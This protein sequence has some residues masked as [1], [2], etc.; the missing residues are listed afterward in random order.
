MTDSNFTGSRLRDDLRIILG[1]QLGIYL[2]SN[3]VSSQAI[4]ILPDQI[5]GYDYPPHGT[6]VSGIEVV[7]MRPYAKLSPRIGGK[8]YLKYYAW[9]IYLKS[10]DSNGDLTIAVE[11]A[12][13]GC[14]DKGYSLSDPIYVPPSTEL[15]I[16]ASASFKIKD[17]I[18]RIGD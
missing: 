6:T 11:T 17:K 9:D 15:G 14:I 12:I 7:I 13:N 3:G 4:A 2:F 8:D 16:L 18:I 1:S 10:W 5:C